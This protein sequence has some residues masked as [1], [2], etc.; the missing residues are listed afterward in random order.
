M[1]VLRGESEALFPVQQT[2][3]GSV[4]D[5]LLGRQITDFSLKDFRGKLHALA[6]YKDH[7]ALVVYFMGTECPL[8]KIY[9]PRVQQIANEFAVAGVAVLAVNSNVQDSITELASYS[10]VHGLK[11][12]ILKDLN[13]KVADLFGATRTPQIFVLDPQRKIRYYGRVDAQFTFGSG[14]GLAKPQAQREDLAIALR[15]ML[16]GKAVSVPVTEARG[17]LIGRA[18]E[19]KLD[20]P[21]TYSDQISRLLQRRCLECHRTGQIAP[22]SMTDY[23]EV[24]GWGEMI[25]E[26][27]RE[28]RM[29]P[30]HAN[31]EHGRFA[32]ENRLSAAEKQLIYTWVE[33]GCPRGDP[34][35]LPEPREFQED[36]FLPRDPDVVVSLP[37]VEKI[38]S[39]GVENYRY[40]EV[41][42]GFQEDKWIELAEC[43]PGNRAVVHHIIVYVRPP[44]QRTGSRGSRNTDRRGL[45]FLAGFAPGTRPLAPPEGWARKVEA[46]SRFVFQMHYTPIGTSQTDRSSIG[47]LFADKR[48]IT[49]RV[50]T[51]AALNRRFE[52]PRR[53]ANHRVVARKTF[54]RDTFLFSLFPHMHMRGKAFRYVLLYPGSEKKWEVLL[55]VPRFDFN[56]QNAY[57]LAQPKLI[58]KGSVLHCTAYFDNSAGNLA[59][60]DPDQTVRWG[61]QTW[62]EMMIGYI[63]TGIPIAPGELRDD[64]DKPALPAAGE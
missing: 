10:R 62:E 48:A 25:A 44:R 16:A 26:V 53:E 33:N 64:P 35:D 17:C 40:I 55:D 58:P 27:V 21:V 57:V 60:P 56:W 50:I 42:P 24:A 23:E 9:G 11:Y 43:R 30:W 51:S 12:P 38:K 34:A 41:D 2:Q 46:G 8:A 36:W 49:H 20:S 22:F 14:V 18:R 15:Q 13:H 3:A 5:P 59:N 31:P 19:P 29:P 61:D 4:G 63:H 47:L 1:C 7:K 45:V 54:R 32:N 39:V 37:R 28:Q 6:D 52:I